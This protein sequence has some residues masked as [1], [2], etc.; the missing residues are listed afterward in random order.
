MRELLIPLF[1]VAMMLGHAIALGI[2]FLRALHWSFRDR[3]S[4]MAILLGIGFALF[5]TEIFVLG[6]FRVLYRAG[7]LISTAI[8]MLLAAQAQPWLLWRAIPAGG[9]RGS[10]N[11]LERTTM[12][13]SAAAVF[14]SVFGVCAQPPHTEDEVEYHWPAPLFWAVHH[15]WVESPY[16]LTNGPALAEMLFTV[17]ALYGSTTAAHILGVIFLLIITMSCASL[18]NAIGVPP[19]P[20]ALAILSIPVLL[21]SAPVSHNDNIA[22]AFALCAYAAL[23]NGSTDTPMRSSIIVA[24]VALAAAVSTKPFTVLA[25]PGVCGYLLYANY[26]GGH[27]RE[28]RRTAV[29]RSAWVLAA[30]AGTLLIW[31]GHC[32]LHTGQFWDSR[33]YVMATSPADPMWDSAKA[34]GRKARLADYLVEPVIF[35]VTM[36]IG[37]ERGFSGD[38]IGP[39]LL[40]FFPLGLLGLRG[41]SPDRRHALYCLIAGAAFYLVVFSPTAPKTRFHLF[42]WGIGAV[43]AALGYRWTQQQR[44]WIARSCFAGFVFLFALGPLDACRHLYGFGHY[45]FGQKRDIRFGSMTSDL[46]ISGES[47]G[48]SNLIVGSNN[49]GRC[50]GIQTTAG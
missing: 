10:K 15:G 28:S 13:I 4:L 7:F 42:V 47:T 30:V 33:G 44:P 41:L 38:R 50:C 1:I 31:A 34:A 6:E 14:L 11:T 16:R 21:V 39:L 18:A 48:L 46:G 23:L 22:A 8:A 2:L 12:G 17:P 40:V 5:A 32:Y 37:R 49:S 26:R 45:M 24:T 25:A 3:C 19:L 9:K 35:P 43:V 29:T 36:T 20:A 27:H